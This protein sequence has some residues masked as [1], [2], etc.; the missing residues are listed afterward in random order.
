MAIG[1]LIVDYINSNSMPN[2][3]IV[4]EEGFSVIERIYI[5]RV[6]AK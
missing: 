1:F 6:V 2:S 3:D 5:K 4:N